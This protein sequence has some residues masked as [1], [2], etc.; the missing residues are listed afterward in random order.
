MLDH[1]CEVSQLET[2]EQKSWGGHTWGS[3][4]PK[5]LTLDDGTV[6]PQDFEVFVILKH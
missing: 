4:V 1:M 3:H 6:T 5:H 2:N